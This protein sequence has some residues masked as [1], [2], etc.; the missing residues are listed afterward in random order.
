MN[1]TAEI[2][3]GK[4]APSF[5][6]QSSKGRLDLGVW[7]GRK[8][9]VLLFM[10]G[11]DEPKCRSYIESFERNRGHY[12]AFDADVVVVTAGVFTDQHEASF[13]VVSDALQVFSDYGVLG[14]DERAL[15]GV[16][17]VDRYGEIAFAHAAET[18]S[19]LPHESRI[20]KRLVGAESVCPECGVPEEHWLRFEDHED[21]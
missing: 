9:L 17:V 14:E 13:P 12:R 16:V 11:L 2:L 3:V 18:C 8:A 21:A 4:R 20:A 6:L 15:C 10:P 5:S 7:L 19:R 1:R